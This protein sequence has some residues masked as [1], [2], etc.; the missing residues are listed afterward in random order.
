MDQTLLLKKNK[1]HSTGDSKVHS[2]SRIIV[3]DITTYLGHR[4]LELTPHYSWN[5]WLSPFQS[6]NSHCPTRQTGTTQDLKQEM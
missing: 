5:S 2:G 4:E 6:L 1:K 3:L